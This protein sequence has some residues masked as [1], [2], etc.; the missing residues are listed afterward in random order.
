MISPMTLSAAAWLSRAMNASI[1]SKSRAARR[2]QL[3]VHFLR[4]SAT[5]RPLSRYRSLYLLGR[6]DPAGGNIRV[7][8]CD[9]L[10]LPLQISEMLVN[11]G[12]G[13]G[14]G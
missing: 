6:Q 1:S 4:L 12:L 13:N 14:G 8:P 9:R 10:F 5:P 11:G 7:A 3:S 2:D